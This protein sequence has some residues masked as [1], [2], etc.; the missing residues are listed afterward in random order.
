LLGEDG[1]VVLPALDAGLGPA[2]GHAAG[3]EGRG[4]AGGAP[5]VKLGPVRRGAGDRPAV[6]R[7]V[8]S[9]RSWSDSGTARNIPFA[10][11]HTKYTKRRPEWPYSPPWLAVPRVVVRRVDAVA[12]A[13][14]PADAVHAPVAGAAAVAVTALAADGAARREPCAKAAPAVSRAL[15]TVSPLFLARHR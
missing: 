5:G 4:A 3:P 6:R 15:P 13:A 1:G 10:I 11:L 14:A 12:G 7:A 8:P 9:R 2:A